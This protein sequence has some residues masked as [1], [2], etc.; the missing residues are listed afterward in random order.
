M[1]QDCYC[2]EVLE[3]DRCE[4]AKYCFS[5]CEELI[6]IYKCEK[7]GRTFSKRDGNFELEEYDWHE[8]GW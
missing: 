6:N 5:D 7:C 8:E 2:G 3:L 4:W 1:S